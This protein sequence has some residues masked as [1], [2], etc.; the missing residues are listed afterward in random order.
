MGQTVGL[1]LET[2]WYGLD[3]SGQLVPDQRQE[4]TS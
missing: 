4:S 1:T 2:A 3:N